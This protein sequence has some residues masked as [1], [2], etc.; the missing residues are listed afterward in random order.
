MA[1][2]FLTTTTLIESIVRRAHIPENQNTFQEAD[3]LAFANEEMMIGLLPCIMK[4]HEEFYVYVAE[5]QLNSNQS[6][7]PI[8]DRSVGTK[9]RTLFY[10]DQSRNLQEMARINP[11]DL[12]FYQNRS[13]INF[14]RAFY[15]EN[16]NLV[17]VPEMGSGPQGVLVMK[18]Y[19][20]PNQLVDP[21]RVAT[22]TAIDATTGVIQV[23]NIPSVFQLGVNY[24]VIEATGGHK[25]KVINVQPIAINS[26]LN[27]IQ[28]SPSSFPTI[29]PDNVPNIGQNTINVGDYI[30]LANETMV[31]QAPEDLHSILAQRVACRCLEAQKDAEGLQLA[32]QKLQEMEF[33]LGM[34]VDNRTE[35]QPQKVNALRS[36][37]RAGKFRRRRSTY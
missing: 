10:R 2:S 9:V 7:Y 13:S 28:F 1:D 32:N 17:M 12:V 14:P 37:L 30:N 27:T 5:V 4:M 25:S 26:V 18:Y 35:G 8:P 36:A 34:L 11:E 20:R 15:V 29:Y 6:Q 21:S 22:I 3:F 33:N 23:D 31:I 16:N 19:L 24:D